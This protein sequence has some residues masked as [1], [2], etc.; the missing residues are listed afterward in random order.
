MLVPQ[1]RFSIPIAVVALLLLLLPGAA[2][3]QDAPPISG[4]ETT[5]VSEAEASGGGLTITDV[6][7]G[8]HDGFDRVTFEYVGEGELGWR[9]VYED[10]PLGDG[11]G[12]PIDFDGTV[13][14][15]VVLSFVALPPDATAETFLDDVP[16][17]AGG[18]INEVV[19]DSIFEGYQTFVVGLD[20][21]VPYRIGRLDD[22]MRVV[23]DLVHDETP[24]GPVDAGIGG[25][26]DATGSALPW[27]VV[28]GLVLLAAIALA[29]SRRRSTA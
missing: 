29:V 7:V 10:E 17:P 22:P 28:G 9:V 21:E 15:R 20:Q 27:A 13:G 24:V 18:F 14:L 11:S 8:T 16:G 5:G 3:A 25:A 2:T 6:R 23:I 26:A 12:E 1:R 4:D 19:N